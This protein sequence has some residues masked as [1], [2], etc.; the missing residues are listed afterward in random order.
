LRA[1][2]WID[3][4]RAA[5]VLAAVLA[6]ANGCALVVST[7][8]CSEPMRHL[9]AGPNIV[10][11]PPS[12]VSDPFTFERVNRING[13]IQ[14]AA[15]TMGGDHDM[16]KVI[17]LVPAHIGDPSCRPV[18]IRYAWS[19]CDRHSILIDRE[20][21]TVVWPFTQPAADGGT[22]LRFSVSNWLV[23]GDYAIVLAMKSAAGRKLTVEALVP[24]DD[25]ALSARRLPPGTAESA[26]REFGCDAYDRPS[27]TANRTPI[28]GCGANLQ[29]VIEKR[30]QAE[31]RDWF[32]LNLRDER[33]VWVPAPPREDVARVFPEFELIDVFVSFQKYLQEMDYEVLA[34]RNHKRLEKA[35]GRLATTSI[36]AEN[37]AAD[38]A[39]TVVMGTADLMEGARNHDMKLLESA[40]T[41]FG[42]AT[43]GLSYQSESVN[44][45][46]MADLLRCCMTGE[47]Q[48]SPNR[49]EARVRMPSADEIE[50]HA[51]R[52]W[53]Y[54]KLDPA[55][56]TLVRNVASLLRFLK[57]DGRATFG[58]DS[59]D[60]V[61]AKLALPESVTAVSR[62]GASCADWRAQMEK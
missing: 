44:L 25:V 41:R 48:V 27:A 24:I 43:R 45:Q 56:D 58:E 49:I 34:E 11:A 6:L 9:Q 59:V 23:R 40:A 47:A 14:A 3:R 61:L 12:G 52:M 32:L 36:T 35:V 50:R 4:L 17:R 46:L 8:S 55:N 37:A 2:D 1:A 10:I 21:V 42:S 54:L 28:A 19:G 15:A 5:A 33:K 53:A 31:G 62:P 26:S 13:L 57:E 22:Y 60:E 38:A 51:V 29:A 7:T 18:A 39:A 30:T 16:A 20:P